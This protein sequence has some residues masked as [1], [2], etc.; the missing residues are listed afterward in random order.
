MGEGGLQASS[1]DDATYDVFWVWAI[2]NHD[3]KRFYP[4][5]WLREAGRDKNI[6]THKAPSL[7]GHLRQP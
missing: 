6:T 2:R 4:Y 7:I 5:P 3:Y 1:D